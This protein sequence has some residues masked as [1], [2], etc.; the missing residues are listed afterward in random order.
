[1]SIEQFEIVPITI[2]SN[3]QSGGSQEYLIRRRLRILKI[4]AALLRVKAIN[5]QF[6][7]LKADGSIN[8]SANIAELLELTQ[9]KDEKN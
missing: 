8:D 1:M 4:F 9:L 6:K 7:L 2:T 3:G 5:D